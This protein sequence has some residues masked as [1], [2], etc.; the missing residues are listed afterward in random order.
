MADISAKDVAALRKATGAGMM[1]CKQALEE[2][3]GD[4]EAAKLVLREKGLA[5]AAK[6][7]GRNRVICEADPEYAAEMQ[8]QVA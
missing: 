1:D 4:V 6:R 8:S 5:G 3:D 2:T 7:A